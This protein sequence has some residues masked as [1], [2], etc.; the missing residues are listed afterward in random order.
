M[1]VVLDTSV[2]YGDPLFANANAQ[3]LL[4]HSGANTF[5]IAVPA[6]VV[7][8]HEKKLREQIQPDYDRLVSAATGLGRRGIDVPVP[9]IDV[10]ARARQIHEETVQRLSNEGVVFPA[11]PALDGDEFAKRSVDE[12]KPWGDK[13]RGFRDALIWE[14]VKEFALDEPVLLATNNTDDFCQDD[15]KSKLHPDLINDLENAGIALDRVRVVNSVAAAVED[16]VPP[17]DRAERRV[18]TLLETNQDFVNNVSNEL[19]TLLIDA[20]IELWD[21]VTV[22]NY[23]VPLSTVE[24][25]T[26]TIEDFRLLGGHSLDE[27][28][29][30]ANVVLT[31]EVNAYVK[32][33]FAAPAGSEPYLGLERGLDIDY[34]GGW[35]LAKTG[36]R[37]VRL[38]G[39]ARYNPQTG[40]VSDWTKA[41]MSDRDA[42][43]SPLVPES[44]LPVG[45]EN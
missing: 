26:A 40:E 11:N 42:R 2:L 36:W 5:R 24:V 32:F 25:S 35:A 15:D 39:Q 44:D 27:A 20:R 1:V 45:E 3:V 28:D 9:H 7:L 21:S 30:E 18:A 41:S 19:Y 4:G 16:L 8:E 31:F 6:A 37:P 38:I 29:A 43:N 10:A 13:S 14:T 12:L 23:K 34:V 33:E 22:A 17:A